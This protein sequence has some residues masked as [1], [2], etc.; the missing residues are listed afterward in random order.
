MPRRLKVFQAR[1]GFYDTVV[2]APSQAAA[3]RAW[4]IHQN[5]FA[6]G[7]ARVCEDPKA[8]E[9]AMAHP[10]TPLRRPA[11]SADA[12]GLEP[13]LPSVPKAPKAAAKEGAKSPRS[14]KPKSK[15]KPKADRS[16]LSAAETA[17][18]KLDA[19]RKHEEADFKRRRDD[20]DA[21]REAAQ[22]AYHDDRKAAASA[23]VQ[24][25]KASRKAGGSA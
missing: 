19:E 16:A 3:L 15:P 18:R 10:E 2:A 20:L 23:V 25:R 5:L 13:G 11:G 14:A 6:D 12:F 9:A 8:I 21:A 7:E 17:L 1:L 4:G 22:T 24:A